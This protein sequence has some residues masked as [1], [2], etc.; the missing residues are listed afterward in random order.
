MSISV[1]Y[2]DAGD[3]LA[4][5][6]HSPQNGARYSV[7]LMAGPGQHLAQLAVPAQHR[8]QAFNQVAHKLRVNTASSA[9]HLEDK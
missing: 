5:S 1:V 6:G 2:N 4:A 9:P 3:I 7:A 8:N